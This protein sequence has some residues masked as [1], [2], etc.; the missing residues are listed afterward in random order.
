MSIHQESLHVVAGYFVARFNL[1]SRPVT[2]I[3]GIFKNKQ[4]IR[5]SLGIPENFVSQASVQVKVFNNTLVTI[6]PIQSVHHFVKC[7]IIGPLDSV[8]ENG[9]IAAIH[10]RLA[11]LAYGAPFTPVQLAGSR[12]NQNASGR[13]KV[14]LERCAQIDIDVAH[15]DPVVQ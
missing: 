7:Q 5:L 10:V 9:S 3:K 2:E 8:D 4:R 6:A 13:R 14:V 15:Y 12:E 1:I 11:N